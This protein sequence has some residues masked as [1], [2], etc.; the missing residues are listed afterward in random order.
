MPLRGPT[1][2]EG[3]TGAGVDYAVAHPDG[4]SRACAGSRAPRAAGGPRRC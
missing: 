3:P 4:G 1:V 2:G